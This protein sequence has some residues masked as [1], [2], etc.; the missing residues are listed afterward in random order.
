ML[1]YIPLVPHE[2][3]DCGI[4]KLVASHILQRL[5]CQP[6]QLTG[7][8][9]VNEAMDSELIPLVRGFAINKKFE[10]L[11]KNSYRRSP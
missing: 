11:S 3:D 5:E 7:L 10:Y 6:Q 1:P 4:F 2:A 9:S 8:Q